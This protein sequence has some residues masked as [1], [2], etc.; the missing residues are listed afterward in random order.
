MRKIAG[1][2]LLLLLQ[3]LARA[4]GPATEPVQTEQIIQKCRTWLALY[5]ANGLKNAPGWQFSK[6]DLQ[7]QPQVSRE[8]RTGG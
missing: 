3:G 4:D 2:C 8:G 5:S 7:Q 1:V 6:E